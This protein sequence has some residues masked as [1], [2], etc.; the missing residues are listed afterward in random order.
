M[1]ELRGGGR[2]GRPPEKERRWVTSD[3]TFS[4]TATEALQRVAGTGRTLMLATSHPNHKSDTA[5]IRAAARR[6]GMKVKQEYR[7]TSLAGAI[8]V[9]EVDE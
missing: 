7:P 1:M 9:K 8:Y 5:T 6:L 3:E 2:G 4:G